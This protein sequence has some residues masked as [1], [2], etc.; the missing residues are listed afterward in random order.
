MKSGLFA[1]SAGAAALF[2]GTAIAQA[3]LDP[4]KPA[5]ALT[6]TRKIACSTVDG[7]PAV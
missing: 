3:P 5:D 4:T 1:L 2:A 6:I 7:E